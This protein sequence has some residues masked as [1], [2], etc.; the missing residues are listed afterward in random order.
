[1]TAGA[2]DCGVMPKTHAYLAIAA[3]AAALFGAPVSQAAANDNS[4]PG[5]IANQN[6]PNSPTVGNLRPDHFCRQTYN[7]FRANSHVF[8]PNQPPVGIN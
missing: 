4:S 6:C 1:M 8:T 3:I 5:T 7:E 2:A